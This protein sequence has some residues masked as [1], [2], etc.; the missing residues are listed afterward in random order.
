MSCEWG[1]RFRGEVG[2]RQGSHTDRLVGSCASRDN[3]KLSVPAVVSWPTILSTTYTHQYQRIYV[4][5]ERDIRDCADR[6]IIRFSKKGEGTEGRYVHYP[7]CVHHST[8]SHNTVTITAASPLVV[9]L[10]GA[11]SGKAHTTTDKEGD[12]CETSVQVCPAGAG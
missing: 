7:K 10:T 6:Y 4:H 3:V 1:V 5:R 2:G 8:S 9:V 12:N 11:L